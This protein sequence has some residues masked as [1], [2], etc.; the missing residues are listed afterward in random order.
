MTEVTLHGP[1]HQSPS[2]TATCNTSA[3]SANKR[4]KRKKGNA[5][6][7]TKNESTGRSQRN[8][9]KIIQTPRGL[10][11]PRENK[12]ESAPRPVPARD[13]LQVRVIPRT[14]RGSV[15]HVPPDIPDLTP[16]PMSPAAPGLEEDPGLTQGPEVG[17]DPGPGQ[18]QGLVLG[19]TLDRGRD[20]SPEADADLCL[21]P[22]TGVIHGLQ[23]KETPVKRG[24]QILR[25]DLKA[26]EH[27][28]LDCPLSRDRRL[29]P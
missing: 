10:R 9:H 21:H 8:R 19:P 28:P 24:P 1:T 17:P 16:D 15:P 29:P 4:R 6:E 2:L 13:P 25:R 23:E 26:K 22:E 18:G 3:R 20:P 7:K 5:R 27:L 11:L 12:R 14:K